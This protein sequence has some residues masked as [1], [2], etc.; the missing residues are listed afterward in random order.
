M[1]YIIS[2]LDNRK[3]YR[4]FTNLMNILIDSKIKD[5]HTEDTGR[6]LYQVAS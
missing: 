1:D 2:E 6:K 3:K 5:K 4:H